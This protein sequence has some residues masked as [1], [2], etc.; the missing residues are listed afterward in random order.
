MD[1]GID[2]D[3]FVILAIIGVLG[4]AGIAGGIVLYRRG[5]RASV[6]AF[7]AASVAAG[8]VMWAIVLVSTPISSSTSGDGS[9]GGVPAVSGM[10]AEEVPDCND[11]IVVPNGETGDELDGDVLPPYDSI[12]DGTLGDVPS[13]DPQIEVEPEPNPVGEPIQVDPFPDGET[14]SARD[15]IDEAQE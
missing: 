3:G 4:A 15:A 9:P 14:E 11:T 8:T 13:I 10:C 7:G 1:F 12:A 2:V 6:R 5:A